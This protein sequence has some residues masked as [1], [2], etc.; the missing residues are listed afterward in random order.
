MSQNGAKKLVLVL[1][2]FTIVTEDSEDA[3]LVNTKELKQVTCI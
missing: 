3:I 1:T 2:T